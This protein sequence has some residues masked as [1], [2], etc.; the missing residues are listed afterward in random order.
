MTSMDTRRYEMLVRAHEFCSEYQAR[1]PEEGRAHL[2]T[3]AA[4]VREF[5]AHAVA[6]LATTKEGRLG[7]LTARDALVAELDLVSTTARAL[8]AE[9]P[10]LA[11]ALRRR[12]STSDRGLITDSLALA[13][14]VEP[15]ARQFVVL[16]MPDT[17]PSGLQAAIQRF[18]EAVRYQQAGQRAHTSARMSIAS[19]WASGLSALLKLDALVANT[20]RDPVALGVWGAA[21]RV[22]SSRPRRRRRR[23]SPPAAPPPATAP[24]ASGEPADHHVST[25]SEPALA[26]DIA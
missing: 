2:E 15:F 22:Q 19:A 24:A 13:G 23:A 12:R 9:A 7:K 21:R 14:D 8:A 4:A 17:F 18:E 6:R 20:V 3:L 26:S 1:F 25:V 10:A 5:N 16:G 11:Q